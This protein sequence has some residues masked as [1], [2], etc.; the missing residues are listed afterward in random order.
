MHRPLPAVSCALAL[1]T[2]SGCP[3]TPQT[4]VCLAR[5]A[6]LGARLDAGEELQIDC[7]EER[8]SAACVAE[9]GAPE[10]CGNELGVGQFCTLFGGECS[11]NPKAILCTLISGDPEAPPVCTMPCKWDDDCGAG[12]FCAGK[13]GQKG[14]LPRVCSPDNPGNPR[15]LPD[16]GRLGLDAGEPAPDA[17]LEGP[18][19]GD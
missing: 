4:D 7:N 15:P 6:T 10:N 3:N 8:A 19:A 17:G 16:A 18:D 5:R 1:L 13:G 14:C 9:C 11:H 2:A 12:A